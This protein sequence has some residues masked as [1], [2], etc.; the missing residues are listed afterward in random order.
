MPRVKP[1]KLQYMLN[2]LPYELQKMRKQAKL[3]QRKLGDA[4]GYS[5]NHISLV[6]T[7]NSVPNFDMLIHWF[8]ECEASDEAILKIMRG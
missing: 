5:A 1:L 8:S 3:S 7:G 6:E 4:I 2:D